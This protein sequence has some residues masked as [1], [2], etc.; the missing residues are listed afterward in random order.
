MTEQELEALLDAHRRSAAGR[1]GPRRTGPGLVLREPTCPLP[2]APRSWRRTSV[3]VLTRMASLRLASSGPPTVPT[4]LGM[5]VLGK[6]YRNSHLAEAMRCLGYA[7]ISASASRSP[8]TRWR[9][10]NPPSGFRVDPGTVFATVR[11]CSGTMQ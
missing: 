6:D 3:R 2:S 8:A 11:R 1:R 10:G 5:L 4:V 7:S 9:N